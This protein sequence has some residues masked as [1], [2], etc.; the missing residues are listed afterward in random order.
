[1]AHNWIDG[2]LITAE[3]LNDN[4][5]TVEVN[6]TQKINT[7]NPFYMAPK[8]PFKSYYEDDIKKLS[9]RIDPNKMNI[10]FLTDNHYQTGTYSPNAVQH[11]SHMTALSRLSGNLDTIVLGGDNI[12]GDLPKEMLQNLTSGFTNVM[13]ST[14]DPKTDVFTLL[15][16]HDT[17]VGQLGGL[18][19]EQTLNY[20]EVKKYYRTGELLYNEIRNGDSF[21]GFKDYPDKKV[22]VIFLNS[23]DNPDTITENGLYKYNYLMT[24]GYRQEQLSWLAN[25]ALSVPD[26]SWHVIVFTHAPV[27][28]IFWSSS[29]QQYNSDVLVGILKAFSTGTSFSKTDTSN[30][31]YSVDI[32]VSYSQKGNLVGVVSGH[33]HADGITVNDGITYVETTSSLC[34]AGDAGQ[35]RLVNTPTEDAWDLFTIDVSQKKVNIYRFGGFGQDREFT[36]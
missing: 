2:E 15:G 9:S 35:G 12:N 22:R 25:T 36:Y 34:Y 11:Y 13:F 30:P 20:S 29:S 31:D 27:P 33:I 3:K 7:E 14:S 24:S 5:V 6:K 4:A 8:T 23:F 21:Y 32:D 18:D 28:G 19:P 16:N 10:G 1:M 26:N 17:G